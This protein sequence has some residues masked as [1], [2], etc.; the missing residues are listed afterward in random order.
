MGVHGI[1]P[2]SLDSCMS[3]TVVSHLK[4]VRMKAK[5]EYD[6]L[7]ASVGQSAPPVTF[8]QVVNR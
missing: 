3:F 8:I 1:V 6:H 4:Q 7:L 5:Q 2:E